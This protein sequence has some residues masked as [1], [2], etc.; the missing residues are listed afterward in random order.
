MR[1]VILAVLLVVLVWTGIAPAQEQPG[2]STT[3]A[4]IVCNQV[5]LR[6]RVPAPG[7]SVQDRV[8]DVYRRIVLAWSR[9]RITADK[10]TLRQSRGTWSIYAGGTLI[11]TVQQEDARA[12]GTT[13][14]ALA[15]GWHAK[16]RELLPQCKPDINPPNP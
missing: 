6:I 15:Q 12:N 2:G 7:M 1:A 5:A 3:N 10:V 14:A 9:E 16:L 13:V 8:A 11:V 4:I